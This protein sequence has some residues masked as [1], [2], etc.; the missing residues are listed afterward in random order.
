M[1]QIQQVFF[2]I[3]E[4]LKSIVF[5]H[6]FI[7]LLQSDWYPWTSVDLEFLRYKVDGDGWSWA[8]LWSDWESNS[9]F[10]LNYFPPRN[11]KIE[12]TAN[13]SFK[14]TY[15]ALQPIFLLSWDS[16]KHKNKILGRNKPHYSS[17]GCVLGGGGVCSQIRKRI[18]QVWKD[19]E[20]HQRVC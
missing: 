2:K 12:A 19:G 13:Y 17:W 16:C 9:L 10:S 11:N 14:I 8:I 7:I 15:H 1:K 6:K 20:H 4:Y 18:Q 3:L 5:L